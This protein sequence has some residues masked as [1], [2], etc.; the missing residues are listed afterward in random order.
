MN[1]LNLLTIGKNNPLATDPL[2]LVGMAKILI[3]KKKK[4][5]S[6]KFPMTTIIRQPSMLPFQN[7][8]N[9]IMKYKWKLGHFLLENYQ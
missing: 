1:Y 8:P 7:N 2:Y 5:S 4:G 3:K 9:I 6:K